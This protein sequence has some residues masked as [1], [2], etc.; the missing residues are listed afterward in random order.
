MFWPDRGSG[1]SVEPARHPVASAV[2]QYFTEGGPGVPPTV[3]GGDWFNQITNEI[4]NVVVAAGLEPSKTDD[5]QLLQAFNALQP[6]DLPDIR[7]DPAG[8]YFG[9]TGVVIDTTAGFVSGEPFIV[10]DDANNQWVMYLFRTVSGAPYVRCYYRVL[11]YTSGMTGTWGPPIEMTSLAAYHKFV[12]MVDVDGNP[13]QVDGNY[14]GYASSFT[15]SLGSKLVYHFTSPTLTG[16]W[17][18]GSNVLPKGDAGSKDEFFTDTPYAIYKDGTVYLWYMGAPANPSPTYGLAIR[19]LRAI[20]TNPSG[21]FTKE[22]TDVI[23]PDT[24]NGNWDYGWLGGAQIRRRPNGRFMMVYNGGDV[25]PSFAG[26]EPNT[27]RIGYAYSDN[28]DG[29]WVKDGG[30]PYFSP[31]GSPSDAVESTNIWRGHLAYDHLLGHWSMFYNSGSGTEKITRA[32]L[33]IYDY[34]YGA[35]ASNNVINLTSSLQPVTN[36]RINL[37]AGKYRVV[38]QCNL[39]ADIDGTSPALDVETSLRLNGLVYGKNTTFV[40]S[41]PYENS[42][43][44]LNYLV[45][46]PMA[47]YVDV[48]VQVTGGTPPSGAWLRN[49]RVNVE[50]I[51]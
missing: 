26:D 1:V 2:R 41:Y 14:H 3:P 13:V 11:P 40:G 16:P 37:P 45:N 27:S 34:K 10:R 5:T 47:G 31:S 43:T 46:L 12:L 6:A 44:I 24:V 48:A 38:A 28:L 8:R 23:L 20:A 29:P 33:A 22:Y 42:D 49:L 15:G 39:L 30:N 32:D 51:N 18:L 35:G 25:R 4:L 21:P 9:P 36:S 7:I 50:Q 17:A 19:M